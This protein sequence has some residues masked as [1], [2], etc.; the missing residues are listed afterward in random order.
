ML[1][2]LLAIAVLAGVLALG[3]ASA[4]DVDPEKCPHGAISA[5]GPVD[6]NGNGDASA[7]AACLDDPF[8]GAR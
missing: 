6:A 3:S 8:V 2:R 7:D 1:L 4:S 5:F